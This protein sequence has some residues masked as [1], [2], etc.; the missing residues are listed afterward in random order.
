MFIS[1]LNLKKKFNKNKLGKTAVLLMLFAIIFTMAF[2]PLQ[3]VEGFAASTTQT[4]LAE[5]WFSAS[6]YLD[7]TTI[8]TLIANEGF[9]TSGKQIII[10]VIDT[11]IIASHPIFEGLLVE[12][13]NVIDN[14]TNIIDDTGEH[15]TAGLRYHGTHV[16]G[17]IAQFIRETGLQN[18]IKIMPIKAG[19]EEALFAWADVVDAIDYAA[20]HGASL[21]NMS[22][23]GASGDIGATSKA[24]LTSSIADALVENCLSLAA[25]GNEGKNS[26]VTKY[27]PAAIADTVSVM[28]YNTLGEKWTNSNY[29]DSYDV[30]SPGVSIES[31]YG[32]N[33]YETKNGTSM[34]TPIVTFMASVL[35]LKYQNASTVKDIIENYPASTITYNGYSLKKA[36]LTDM[37][38]YVPTEHIEI[39]SSDPSQLGNTI[40][41]GLAS[42]R[43]VT[44]TAKYFQ[45]IDGT[46][47]EDTS[48]NKILY[49]TVTRDGVTLV[50]KQAVTGRSFTL[51]VPATVGEY[52]IFA[53][54]YSSSQLASNH[55]IISVRASEIIIECDAA[56]TENINYQTLGSTYPVNFT[57]KIKY[58]NSESVEVTESYTGNLSWYIQKEESVGG[59]LGW[60]DYDD[61]ES[62]GSYAYDSNDKL[63]GKFRI[64]ACIGA[65]TSNSFI[66]NIAYAV[67]PDTVP[68][69][70]TPEK[71]K[72]D[73]S[74]TVYFK[75]EGYDYCNPV[76][77]NSVSWYVGKVE[78]DGTVTLYRDGSN[79]EYA[80][81]A[82]EGGTY[83]V[84]GCIN[85]V[86][87]VYKEIKVHDVYV[88]Y[89][90]TF[91]TLGGIILACIAVAVIIYFRK[92]KAERI[93]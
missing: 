48:E 36:N 15:D 53:S 35:M 20:E 21:I 56:F 86:R 43:D 83:I 54:P 69:S 12:G 70:D 11:G 6:N 65:L 55:M 78:D 93:I 90:I 24:N 60:Y 72:T 80:F 62:S 3:G 68:A 51:T 58:I 7:L 1:M 75:I 74:E 17:I 28:A 88:G 14:S 77:Y 85:G 26:A 4:P 34:A 32:L 37:M 27:Y 84:E 61:L 39:I 82:N 40:I 49:W 59:V 89:V 16:A 30:I 18:N 79:L 46:L 38:N 33:L 81:E 91:S 50:D 29:G 13:Y 66:I 23:A 57:T 19:D 64:Y 71:V 76:D 42:T 45:N 2:T 10:A 41:Q 22:L 87:V 9:S 92:E 5:Q 44:F 73:T 25:A 8:K 67:T 52:E 47:V 63:T 31:S